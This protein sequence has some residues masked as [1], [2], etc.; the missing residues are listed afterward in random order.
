LT[1]S[2]K[3]RSVSPFNPLVL[4]TMTSPDAEFTDRVA[5][6]AAAGYT[7]IGIRPKHRNR[8]LEQGFTDTDLRTILSDHGV[9][10]VEVEVL[11][12]WGA[13][14]ATVAKSRQHEGEIYELVDA[15]GGRHLT[16]TGAGLQGPLDRS[17]EL[18][19]GVCDRAAEHGLKIALEFLPWTEVPDADTARE[20]VQAAARP[21]G[22]VQV[23]SWHL[24]SL[25]GGGI[26]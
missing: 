24:A 6:A 19:A 16:V 3:E 5:G 14:D 20:I 22:G 23:D 18:F 2:I 17:A 21:N 15:L 1:T 11:S 4:C 26:R 7:G 12:G 8:A 25:P 10:V 9:A 13:D